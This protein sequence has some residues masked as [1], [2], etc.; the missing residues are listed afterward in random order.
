MLL[1]TFEFFI[2]I[3][4]CFYYLH[5]KK[6]ITPITFLIFVSYIYILFTP[7]LYFLKEPEFM[8]MVNSFGL[9]T[10]VDLV[11]GYLMYAVFLIIAIYYDRKVIKKLVEN[12]SLTSHAKGKYVG[13]EGIFFILMILSVF[14]ILFGMYKYGV[15]NFYYGYTGNALINIGAGIGWRS[16]VIGNLFYYYA[17]TVLLIIKPKKKLIFFILIGVSLSQ[18]FGGARF[19]TVSGL[20]MILFSYNDFR[21]RITKN[22]IYLML[23]FTIMFTFFGAYRSV[24]DTNEINFLSGLLEFSFVSFGYYNLIASRDFLDVHVFIFLQDSLIFSLPP[25]FDKYSYIV[26]EDIIK[27]YFDSI[28]DISP[29]GGTFMLTDFY[30]YFGWLF[31]IPIIILMK[32]LRSLMYYYSTLHVSRY[33]IIIN[34]TIGLVS[35][36]FLIN[37]LRNQVLFSVS[38]LVK[39]LIIFLLSILVLQIKYIYRIKK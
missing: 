5:R 14:L 11:N 8:R 29:V 12:E 34:A 1:L 39:I 37:L 22:M 20:I 19:M 15:Y 24:T 6:Y 28:K 31:F 17:T 36:F 16:I 10:Y 30:L 23:I 21:I 26:R 38:M 35:S 13:M 25:I 4:L 3:W 18:L 32:F 7:I 27:L 9:F 33:K 2:L